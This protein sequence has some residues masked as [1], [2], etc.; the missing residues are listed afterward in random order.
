MKGLA[1]VLLALPILAFAGKEEREFMKSDVTPAIEEAQKTFKASCGCGLKIDVNVDSF[2]TK[3]HLFQV[4]YTAQNVGEES[5]KYCTDADSKK[6]VC[7]MKTLEIKK[8]KE[9]AFSFKSNKGIAATDGNSY[10]TFD[11]MTKELDK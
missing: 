5:K 11:M 9:T 6:A 7:K 8:D 2:K 10:P 1:L 3:D 4:K